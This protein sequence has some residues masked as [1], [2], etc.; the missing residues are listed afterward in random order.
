VVEQAAGITSVN[1]PLRKYM[2]IRIQKSTPNVDGA[3]AG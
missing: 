3:V 2:A 1:L